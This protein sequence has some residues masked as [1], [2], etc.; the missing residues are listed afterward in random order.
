MRFPVGLAALGLLAATGLTPALAQ[1]YFTQ[2]TG[3]VAGNIVGHV[4]ILGVIPQDFASAASLGKAWHVNVSAG[5]SPEVDG[6]Y[7][8]TPSWAVEVI[9][10]T[11][12][13]NVSVVA[14][15]THVKVGS[16]WVLP[17]TISLQYHLPQLGVVRPYAGLGATVAFFYDSHAAPGITKAGYS[18]AVGPTVEAGFD[19]PLAGNWLAN[20][21]VKQMFLVTGARVDNGAVRALT[22]L[23]PTVV[24]V[25][26]G[27]VF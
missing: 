10:A 13:H 2:P 25:G 4:S 17:P 26:V 22:E 20:L 15:G 21:D 9:A 23:S 12:R 16:T 24:G 19:V 8:L 6:S 1:S 27:Y 14:G 3:Y 18:T 11:T 7:F 5:I